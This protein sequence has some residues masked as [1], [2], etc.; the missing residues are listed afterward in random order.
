MFQ[1]IFLFPGLTDEEDSH[2]FFF[3]FFQCRPMACSFSLRALGLRRRRRP[4]F[5]PSLRW[6]ASWSFG[7]WPVP[8]YPQQPLR[9]RSSYVFIPSFP[10]GLNPLGNVLQVTFFSDVFIPHSI[11][12][13]PSRNR[14][15]ISAD[16]ISCFVRSVSARVSAPYVI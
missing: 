4:A 1:R 16:L 5:R 13:C 11:P 14:V 10:A 8:G 9:A 12:Q 7:G 3:L 6:S 2:I 15:L